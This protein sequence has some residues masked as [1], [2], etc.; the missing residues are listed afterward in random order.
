MNNTKIKGADGKEH[1]VY[2]DEILLE[3]VSALGQCLGSVKMPKKMEK[4]IIASYFT[5]GAVKNRYM[6]INGSEIT[7]GI[8]HN[9]FYVI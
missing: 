6:F 4:D 5:S 7:D 2:S 1:S 3:M 9:R 8:N